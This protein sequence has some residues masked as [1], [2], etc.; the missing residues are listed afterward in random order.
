MILIPVDL[1][2]VLLLD[3]VYDA[4]R[5]GILGEGWATE[6]NMIFSTLYEVES[7]FD[8]EYLIRSGRK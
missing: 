7:A 6:A 3:R 2:Q 1:P 4:E 5:E 8:E